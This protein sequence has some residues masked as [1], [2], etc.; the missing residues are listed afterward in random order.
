MKKNTFFVLAG[1]CIFIVACKKQQTTTPTASDTIQPVISLSGNY[2]DTVSLNST[3]TDPG[4]SAQD[5][6]DGNIT[7]S[8]VKTGSVN[9][10]I[11]N[12][13]NLYY[14]VTDNAGNKA[15]TMQRTIAVVNDDDYLIGTYIAVPSCGA[16]PTAQYSVNI[17]T[18]TTVN[19]QIFFSKI[20]GGCQST[21]LISANTNGNNITIPNQTYST[22]MYSGTGTIGGINNFTITTST[23]CPSLGTYNCTI[24]HTK[25]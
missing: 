5:N 25:Q 12:N 9:T 14:N 8:I 13:Y 20:I 3:Y 2:A 17:T 18:S 16:T 10:N 15:V 7:S 1:L 21:N 6:Q 24:T 19:N 4:A 11:K 23:T 22:S